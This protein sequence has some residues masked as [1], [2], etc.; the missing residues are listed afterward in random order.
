MLF[1]PNMTGRAGMKTADTIIFYT[2]AE[3]SLLP[4]VSY[5]EPKSW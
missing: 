4:L 1:C 2:D 5:E 3:G